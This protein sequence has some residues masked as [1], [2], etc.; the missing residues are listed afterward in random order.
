MVIQM[1]FTK[2]QAYGNDYVYI[3]LLDQEMKNPSKWAVFVSDRHKGVGSDGMILVCPSEKADFRMRVFNPDGSEAE[4][5]GNGLRSVGKLVYAKGYTDKTDFTVE[6]LGGIKKVHLWVENGK[7]V[8]VS[9]NIGRPIVEANKIPVTVT[10]KRNTLIGYKYKVIDRIFT[11]TAISL[12]NPHCGAEC[13]D[14]FNLDIQKYGPALENSVIFP[15]KANIHFYEVTDRNNINMRAWER[16]CG[17][18]LA[19]ATGCST[20]VYSA[21]LAGKV[22]NSVDVHQ[23]GGIVQ[24]DYDSDGGTITMT[25]KTEIVFDGTIDDNTIDE[26]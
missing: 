21:F 9:A 23:R 4:M 8:N 25:G 15:Q 3:S 17:E 2:M 11:L 5:C 1:R 19:C 10:N 24:I 12:G 6:T 13:E 7:V 22:S 14:V 16:N 18:T 20:A 26:V